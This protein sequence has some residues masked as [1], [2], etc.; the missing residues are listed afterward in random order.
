MSN[1]VRFGSILESLLGRT[2]SKASPPR[3][4][5]K[6]A[7]S[8]HLLTRKSQED[9]YKKIPFKTYHLR[10][11]IGTCRW[12]WTNSTAPKVQTLKL[13]DVFEFRIVVESVWSLNYLLFV[14]KLFYYRILVPHKKMS[15]DSFLNIVFQSYFSI[16]GNLLTKSNS[17]LN[18]LE[19]CSENII[20]L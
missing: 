3:Y 15:A 10:T 13:D 14:W 20:I 4:T 18:H 19:F 8:A 5:I 7:T 6:P 9:A 11:T 16:I 17:V 12:I 2:D 1:G